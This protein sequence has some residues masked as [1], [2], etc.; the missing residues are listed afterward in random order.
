MDLRVISLSKLK[1][2]EGL[3]VDWHLFQKSSLVKYRQTKNQSYF[4]N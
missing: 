1:Y 2:I 3:M 4:K